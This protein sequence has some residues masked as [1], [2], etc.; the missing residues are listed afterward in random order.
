[1]EE[2]SKREVESVVLAS[3]P[4]SCSRCK[5]KLFYIGSGKYKC[6]RCEYEV[7]DDFGKVKAFLEENGPCAAVIIADSTGVR[8][9]VIEY[10]LKKGRLEILENSDFYL[11]CEKCGCAIRY[12]RYCP[13]CAKSLLGGIKAVFHEDVGECP[14]NPPI[15]S[16]AKM[17]YF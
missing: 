3:R 9:D 5:G 1:M 16:D 15:N 2:L 10:F 7:M 6:E 8:I 13:Q 11:Q 17:R 12:G 14:K 4:I